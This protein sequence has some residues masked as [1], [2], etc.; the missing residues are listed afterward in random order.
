VSFACLLALVPLGPAPATAQ[1]AAGVDV[2]RRVL[3]DASTE[4]ANE[5]A[6]ELM[7]AIRSALEAGLRYTA[8]LPTASAEDSLVI[9]RQISTRQIEILENMQELAD[10]LIELEGREP[11]ADLRARVEDMFTRVTPRL[12]VHINQVRREIDA[13]RAG[14]ATADAEG[15]FRMEDGLARRTAFL[16]EV[17]GLS[18]AHV[19]KLDELG[20]DSAAARDSLAAFL[21]SRA[22]ELSGRIDLAL[23]RIDD[24][25]ARYAEAPDAAIGLT[26]TATHR[27]LGTNS[28]SLERTADLL[29]ELQLPTQVYRTQLLGATRDLASGLL[30][31]GAAIGLVG[32]TIQGFTDWLAA[33]GPELFLKVVLLFVIVI[34]AR[35]FTRLV[36]HGLEKALD[37][38]KLKLS[39]LLR[40]MIVTTISNLVM[41]FGLLIALSQ[42]GISLGPLVAGLG[43]AGFIVGFALQDTLGNF[44]AGIM[45]LIYRPYDVGDLIEVGGVFGKVDEMSLVSSRILTVDN[46]TLVVPNSKIWG[47]V[48]K[49]VT[50]QDTRRVDMVFGIGYADDIPKTERV[51]MEILQK[52]DKVLADPEPVVKLHTLNESSVD[53]IVRPWVAVDDYWDVHWDVTRAVKM[54]FD[55]EGITIPF[56]QRDVHLFQEQS[57]PEPEEPTRA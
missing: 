27:N 38:S 36:R 32:R 56:P 50:A 9:Q 52:H 57:P 23:D 17:Y 45:I 5:R 47:D 29:D 46:Q 54:R 30:D 24:L 37:A 11:Q 13:V 53:F 14:R 7:A 31:G 12:W 55:E 44:A 25:D 33:N 35:M 40:R 20:L 28:N 1:D 8:V 26:L 39:Q 48:I 42:I 51:L 49:N 19:R 41:I 4:Q 34:V 3:A 43:V 18:L 15:L 21:E 16:D 6:G 2:A 10:L 22:D